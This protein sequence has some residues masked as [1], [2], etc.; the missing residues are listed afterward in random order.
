MK[1]PRR[2]WLCDP[3]DSVWSKA[4]PADLHFFVRSKGPARRVRALVQR[5]DHPRTLSLCPDLETPTGRIVR[6]DG[7]LA[8]ETRHSIPPGL[9]RSL[10]SAPTL[11]K[12]PS[13]SAEVRAHVCAR[14]LQWIDLRKELPTHDKDGKKLDKAADQAQA[15]FTQFIDESKVYA[16]SVPLEPV[17]PCPA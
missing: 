9:R 16:V 4:R 15:L 6:L 2:A 17:D 12:P 14:D 5:T 1:R 3:R 10:H 11:H 13:L 7:R 8:E